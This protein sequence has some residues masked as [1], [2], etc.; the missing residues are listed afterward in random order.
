MA[1]VD[2]PNVGGVKP[3]GRYVTVP[4]TDLFGMKHPGVRLNVES[5]EAGQTYFLDNERAKTIED[6]LKGYEQSTRRILQPRQ[7]DKALADV[8]RGS[9]RGGMERVANP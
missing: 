1:K 5:Y 9:Q 4:E 6:A 8:A 2:L 3:E 7:D